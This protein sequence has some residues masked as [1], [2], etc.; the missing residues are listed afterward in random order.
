MAVY[1]DRMRYL[2]LL[3]ALAACTYTPPEGVAPTRAP[4][5]VHASMGKTWNAVI[6]LFADRNIPIRTIDRSSGFIA[7]DALAVAQ[8]SAAATWANCGMTNVDLAP[9]RAVYNVVVRGDSVASTVRVTVTW[10]TFVSIQGRTDSWEECVTTG[11]WESD[12]EA[13]IKDRAERK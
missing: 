11:K 8:D 7:T 5:A 9:G 10:S 13:N 2:T 4:T 3:L 1:L 12:A 6:D